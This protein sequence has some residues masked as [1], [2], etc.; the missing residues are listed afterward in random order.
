MECGTELKGRA[1]QKFCDG[2]CRSA[3]HNRQ[4]RVFRFAAK[5]ADAKSTLPPAPGR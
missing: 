3:W 5:A 1:D 4:R 2:L